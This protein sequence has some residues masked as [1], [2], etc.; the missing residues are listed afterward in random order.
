M[1][2]KTI[3]ADLPSRGRLLAGTAAALL[4]AAVILVAIVL[5][6]EYGIDPTGAGKALGLNALY[7]AGSET[8]DAPPTIN[9]PITTPSV[10]TSPETTETFSTLKAVWQRDT[11]YRNDELSLTLAPNQGGEIKALMKT[12]ERFVFSWRSD[13]AVNFDMHGEE[14]NAKANEYTSFWKGRDTAEGHGAFTA[15]FD[16]THGWYWRNRGTKTVK[17]TVS[18][19]GFY[20]KLFYPTP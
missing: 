7:V 11:A 6:A 10:Q 12:G 3:S 8:D 13:G 18:T 20:E 4:A 1:N 17:V 16:G 9:N 15:P 14:T 5:P 2:E 19:S